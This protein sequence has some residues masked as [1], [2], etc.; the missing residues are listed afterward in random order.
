MTVLNAY[1]INERLNRSQHLFLAKKNEIDERT[2]SVVIY[3]FMQKHSKYST[4]AIYKY[5]QE[6]CRTVEQ[7][8]QTR[9]KKYFRSK[10]WK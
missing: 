1:E 6:K 3:I 10:T 4:G 8:L 7:N 9:E 2:I 5:L